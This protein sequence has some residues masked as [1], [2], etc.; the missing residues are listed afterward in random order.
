MGWSSAWSETNLSIND[1]KYLLADICN[2]INE[3]LDFIS[4]KVNWLTFSGTSQTPTAND[5]V[6]CQVTGTSNSWSEICKQIDS[7]INTLFPTSGDTQWYNSTF[8]DAYT[9]AEILTAIGYTEADI[10]YTNWRNRSFYLAIKSM[11][12]YARYVIDSSLT[13]FDSVDTFIG[14]DVVTPPYDPGT[15]TKDP[16]LAWDDATTFYLSVD[17]GIYG[18]I[19][20]LLFY[21]AI[22][23]GDS[24]DFSYSVPTKYDDA[25]FVKVKTKLVVEAL[26][27][28]NIIPNDVDIDVN[29]TTISI[30]LST[31]DTFLGGEYY[32]DIFDIESLSATATISDWTDLPF[33]IT[34]PVSVE[35]SSFNILPFASGSM[36]YDLNTAFNYT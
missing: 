31:I 6:G 2:A 33:S 24:F 34:E 23:S 29:G 19:D 28:T 32:T 1:V 22:K 14:D 5:F 18:G 17:A 16:E 10:D 25:T 8:T 21:S 13:E 3:R 26:P 35:G 27:S 36:C 15:Y 11:M 30:P 9:R 12:P 7:A 20:F 4:T